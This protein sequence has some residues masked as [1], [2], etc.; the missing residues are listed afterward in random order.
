MGHVLS[1][2]LGYVRYVHSGALGVPWEWKVKSGVKPLT[3]EQ[4]RARLDVTPG[5]DRP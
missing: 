5:G 3:Q 1:L 4:E 2:I